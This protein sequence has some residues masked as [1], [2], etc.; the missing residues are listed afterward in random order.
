[1][2][3]GIQKTMVDAPITPHGRPAHA[4]LSV[5]VLA[6][7]GLAV[8]S[9]GALGFYLHLGLVLLFLSGS[10]ALG[11]AAGKLYVVLVAVPFFRLLT[12]TVPV[13]SS[14]PILQ[15]A[16]VHIPLLLSGLIAARVLSYALLGGLRRN[17]LV[18]LLLALTGPLIG[19]LVYAGANPTVLTAGLSLSGVIEGLNRAAVWPALALLVAGLSEELLFRGVLLTAAVDLLGPACGVAF[20]ALVYASLYL[21]YPW[22]FS[23]LMLLIG[24]LLGTL[25]LRRGTLLGLAF[26]HGFAYVTVFIVMPLARAG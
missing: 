24:V 21:G 13:W 23:A 4:W 10:Y 26:A 17:L 8:A 15:L 22:P 12:M 11:G 25:A 1:V 18:T 16:L 6:G 20:S 9:N 2:L 14:N 7:A 3:E 19:A 5:A